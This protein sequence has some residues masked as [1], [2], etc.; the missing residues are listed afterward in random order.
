MHKPKQVH[1]QA[2]KRIGKY[3]RGT[4]MDGMIIRPD[5]SLKLNCFVGADFAGLWNYEDQQDYS[6]VKS[7]TGFVITLGGTPVV[8][9]SSLQS[10][11]ALS[12][13]EAEYI[14]LSTVMRDLLPMRSLLNELEKMMDK[15]R[16]PKSTVSMVWEDTQVALTLANVEL[17]RM[18]PRSKHIAVKYHWFLSKVQVG[19]IEIKVLESTNQ[20][21]DIFTKGL[22]VDTFVRLRKMLAGW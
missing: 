18:T 10:E 19:K 3:L 6:S 15:I 21:A 14:A 5:P 12:T 16:D 13:M 8:W 7:H 11:I 1:E 4:A 2:I 20:V 9:A 22:R 17:P